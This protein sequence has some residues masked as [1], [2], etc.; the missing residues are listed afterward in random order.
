MFC[1][2]K[3]IRMMVY[4]GFPGRQLIIIV[5]VMYVLN[6]QNSESQVVLEEKYKKYNCLTLPASLSFLFHV[7]TCERKVISSN[8]GIGAPFYCNAA[9]YMFINR[10]HFF[11]R[12]NW[13]FF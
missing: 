12:K 10:G 8:K 6:F 13:T 9:F 4:A 5:S 3:I 1:I 2:K 7:S 11:P